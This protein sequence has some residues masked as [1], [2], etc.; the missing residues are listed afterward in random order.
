MMLLSPLI[1]VLAEK[2]SRIGNYILWPRYAEHRFVLVTENPCSKLGIG[3]WD[4]G[5][6]IY[7]WTNLRFCLLPVPA[8]GVESFHIPFHAANNVLLSVP[9][10]FVVAVF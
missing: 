8:V 4:T 6:R 1:T 7:E 2:L 3:V 10:F 9:T 5:V